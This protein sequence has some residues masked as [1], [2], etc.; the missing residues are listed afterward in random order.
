MRHLFGVLAIGVFAVTMPCTAKT[1]VGCFSAGTIVI[2]PIPPSPHDAQLFTIAV[3]APSWQPISA[4]AIPQNGSIAVILTARSHSV[5][6]A[7]MTCATASIGPLPV[8][9]YPVNLFV[10]DTAR[11]TTFP[12]A[13]SALTVTPDVSVVPGLSDGDVAMLALYLLVAC[14]FVV[15]GRRR[16]ER[17]SRHA[18]VM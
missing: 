9:T 17:Y 8:G 3:G 6:P 15:S 14:W 13:T 16:A 11:E 12:V 4:V 18:R 10:T 1:I 2:K 7:H 5:A